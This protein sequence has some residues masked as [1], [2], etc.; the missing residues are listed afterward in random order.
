VNILH[1]GDPSWSRSPVRTVR[2][3]A[4]TA[5]CSGTDHAAARNHR[6]RAVEHD[7]L[8]GRVKLPH[9]RPENLQADADA[10]DQQQRWPAVGRGT[11]RPHRESQLLA[12]DDDTAALIVVG[13]EEAIIPLAN[14][15]L[16]NMLMP[17]SRLHVYHGGHLDLAT[18]AAELA[19]V[20][21][22][23]LAAPLH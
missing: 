8:R 1:E 18:E 6:C 19:P 20:V 22:A 14:A 17:R 12:A 7:H 15:K 2:R 11:A 23:F 13:D 9:Q 5:W 21:D 4:G 3:S 10:G 16:M